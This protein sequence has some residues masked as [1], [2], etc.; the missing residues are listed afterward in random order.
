M[1]NTLIVVV[2][3]RITEW[4]DKGELP[5]EYFNPDS[6]FSRVIIISLVE[7]SPSEVAINHLVGTAKS[8]LHSVNLISPLG[9]L[10]TFGFT[11]MLVARY[12]SR[13]LSFTHTPGERIAVR[14]YGDAIAGVVAVLLARRLS[15]KSLASI[16]TTQQD[17]SLATDGSLKLQLLDHLEHKARRFTHRF[18]D[19]LTP[20]YS[21][22]VK[23]IP[24]VYHHKTVV[25]SNVIELPNNAVKHSY[26]LSKPVRL[27]TV[28]R[29]IHGKTIAPLIE[30][31]EGRPEWH[32]TVIGNGP[33]REHF[34]GTIR[35]KGLSSRISMTSRLDNLELLA[36]LKAFD[37]FVAHTK[38]EEI[39]KTVIE[40]GLV[41]LPILLNKP[42]SKL[43]T[44]YQNAPITWV[45]MQT[46]DY[47]KS[48][49]KL[50]LEDLETIGLKTRRHFETVFN[51]DFAGKRIADLLLDEASLEID[52]EVEL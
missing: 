41:G 7:D 4:I 31:L 17:N 51:P 46:S 30:M 15:C 47:Q 24:T 44:E 21:P 6:R 13:N 20:V 36:N 52:G 25:V 49:D 9:I 28:G 50:L 3:A 1:N 32:L 45:D 48:L 2:A 23:S 10:T 38:F 35:D 43:P 29:L 33:L 18:I 26:S 14:S 42:N 22:A 27:I 16:H 8:E 19:V 5:K 11:P 34:I 12:L 40:A 39:P 37:I